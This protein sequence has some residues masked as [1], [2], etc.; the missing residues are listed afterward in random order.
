[1]AIIQPNRGEHKSFLNPIMEKIES[2]RK[3]I[4]SSPQSHLWEPR[5]EERKQLR[6]QTSASPSMQRHS[7]EQPSS[8]ALH[9]NHMQRNQSCVYHR[10]TGKGPRPGTS[11]SWQGNISQHPVDLSSDGRNSWRLVA[12]GATRLCCFASTSLS[13]ALAAHS[14]G[15]YLACAKHQQVWL[16]Y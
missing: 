5:P 13:P 10:W 9:W 2:T 16:Y 15:G 8:N 3:T 7:W 11:S 12:W 14:S 1:M 4:R 6:V